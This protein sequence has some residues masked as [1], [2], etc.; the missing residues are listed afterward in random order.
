ME[1]HVGD[2]GVEPM[3]RVLRIAPSSWHEHAVRKADPEKRPQ[4]ARTDEVLSKKIRQVFNANFGVYGVR[5]IWRQLTRQGEDAARCAV[6]RLMKTMG[7]QGII[8]ENT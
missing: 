2:Y 7:L 1:N 6:A 3:C 5:K 8:R 4:R